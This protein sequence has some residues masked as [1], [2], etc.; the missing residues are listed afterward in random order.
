MSNENIQTLGNDASKIEDLTLRES[1]TE[2][3][4][5]GPTDFLLELD[6]IK[7]E[8]KIIR[9]TTNVATYDLKMAK[10]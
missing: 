6:G 7:G 10:K 2:N 5:G 9:P 1:E 3:I 8:S 4:K